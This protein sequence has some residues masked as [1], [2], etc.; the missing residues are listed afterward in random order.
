[1]EQMI[2]T[3]IMAIAVPFAVRHDGNDL[4]NESSLFPNCSAVWADSEFSMEQ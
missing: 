3:F 4:E 2:S 1:M